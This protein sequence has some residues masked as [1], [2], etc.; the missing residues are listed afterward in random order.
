MGCSL[1]RVSLRADILLLANN[2]DVVEIIDSRFELKFEELVEAES[3][4][5]GESHEPP[6]MEILPD[7]LELVS[8]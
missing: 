5:A 6:S 8:K 4:A 1:S 7:S 2:D 3:C